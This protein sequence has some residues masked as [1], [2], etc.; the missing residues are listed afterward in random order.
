MTS[1]LTAIGTATPSYSISQDEA[2]TF[3]EQAHG[4]DSREAREL[5]ILYRASGIRN[6]YSVLPDFKEGYERSLFTDEL[7]TTAH[8]MDIYSDHAL[9]L[10]A[11]A[12]SVC[13]GHV[14]PEEITHLI[15]VSCT[16]MFA[17]GLDIQL[18][19]QL[20][21]PSNVK[22]TA[23]NFM[24]C[25]AA[26]NAIKVANSICKAENAKVLVVCTELCTIHFQKQKDEDSLL[27]NAL[28]GDGSAAVLIE[29]DTNASKFLTLESCECELLPD[30]NDDMAWHIGNFGFE[31]KLSAYVPDIIENGIDQLSDMI[32]KKHD[33][34][35]IHPGGKK[36]LQVLETRLGISKEDNHPAYNV[37]SQYGN[38]SSPTVLFVL[39]EL[40]QQF[41][42]RDD[43]KSILSMAFGPGIT[44]ET[45]TYRISHA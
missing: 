15:T 22:R 32:S 4:L 38:M 30:G 16:G 3:M 14:H 28:F 20:G 29:T 37:L 41:D 1:K 13:L 36:I 26:F 25:Y 33:Y 27:A 21:L 5:K 7:P 43:G 42:A 44:I 17:P 31:M 34:Y 10:S 39:N 12:A 19:R 9:E 45:I 40:F 6:R 35:A 2:L 24:G 8:R 11:Q 23:I 18:I